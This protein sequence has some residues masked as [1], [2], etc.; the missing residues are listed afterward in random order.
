[1]KKE[2]RGQS[3]SYSTRKKLFS[4][5][6]T[7]LIAALLLTGATFA[8]LT[9]SIA[10]EATGIATQI[11][12]NGS[13]EIA[14]LNAETRADL[15]KIR[16]AGVGASLSNGVNVNDVWGNLIDL[17]SKDYGLSEITLM[18]AR[19]NIKSNEGQYYVGENYL[20]APTYGYDGRVVSV[21]G[22]TYGATFNGTDFVGN[23]A[24]P[25]YG[26][27]GLGASNSMSTQASAIATAKTNIVTYTNSAKN[28]AIAALDKNG[29]DLFGIV[30]A[31][32]AN[33]NATFDNDDKAV[34]TA[35][36]TDLKSAY[37]YI[38]SALRQG[39][40]IYAASEIEDE[41][42]FDQVKTAI[43]D[44]TKDI[45][46][47]LDEQGEELNSVIPEGLL[48][49]VDSA[50]EI[51]NSLNAATSACA[52]LTGGSYTWDQIRGIMDYL[53]DMSQVYIGDKLFENMTY[54]DFTALLGSTFTMSLAPSSGVFVS[55]AD[56]TGNYSSWISAMGSKVEIATLSGVNPAYLAGLSDSVKD[57]EAAAGNASE[58]TLKD[59]Y[60][61]ALD[62]A[63]RCNAPLSD[64]LLQTG[65][66]SRVDS[67]DTGVSTMGAGSYMEFSIND[68]SYTPDQMLALMDAVRVAFVDDIGTVMGIAK[69]NTSNRVIDGETI[70]ASLYLY[71][72]TL[73][74]DEFS[75]GSILVMGERRV[76]D[77]AITALTQ[78]TAKAV[79]TIVW[80][81]G[82][83]V[84][85]TMVSAEK[86]ATLT[87]VLNLQFASSA[88]LIPAGNEDLKNLTPKKSDLFELIESAK[89]IYEAGQGMY[90]SASWENFSA[91][92][93]KA[94]AVYND[95]IANDMAVLA[96]A[97]NLVETRDALAEVSF[98][99]LEEKIAEIRELMGETGDLACLVMKDANNL[100]YT[101]KN[102]YTDE[103]FN[104]KIGVINRVNYEKNLKDIGNGIQA[105]I[106]TDESWSILADA[107]YDAEAV[108]NHQDY[109][110]D[111]IISNAI[112]ALDKAY[113]ALARKTYFEAY[114]YEGELYYLA[115]TDAVDTYGKWYDKNH[116]L[117][118]SD[119]TILK[120]DANA[121]LAKIAR[122]AINKYFSVD[123]DA[124]LPTIT[125]LASKYPSLRNEEIIGI[126]WQ[127]TGIFIALASE[128]NI[129]YLYALVEDKLA[130][131]CTEGCV[132]I[133]NA[134]SILYLDRITTD[135]IVPAIVALE[136][137]THGEVE[138]PY[139]PSE[140]DD[141]RVVLR[142]AANTAKNVA[143]YDDL[144]M[145]GYTDDQK[146]VMNNLRDAVSTIEALLDL[147]SLDDTMAATALSAINSQFTAYN[148][149]FEG[150][151]IKQVTIYNSA[152]RYIAVGSE[153]FDVVNG[154]DYGML[155]HKYYSYGA[156]ITG[157][158]GTIK[159]VLLTRSGI[160][161][162]LEET[163]TI[164]AP[165]E[166][167][168]IS[169]DTSVDVG[170]TGHLSVD[171]EQAFFDASQSIYFNEGETVKECFWS[172]SNT[173]IATV[174][175]SGNTAVVTAKAAGTVTISV[176]VT[177]EQGNTY[178]ANYEITIVGAEPEA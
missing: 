57:I 129:D 170:N 6:S 29:N 104:N 157:E 8:W 37:A 90:T 55:I 133:S 166:G 121:E 178:S 177:T 103:Q 148:T 73:E 95:V 30:V 126:H 32:S 31:Y 79:I 59:L 67:D 56:F 22:N 50:A 173:S 11:G 9:I 138:Q 116:N 163:V 112:D 99:L 113:N 75:D 124:M 80:L 28:A 36:I 137:H 52:N 91:A 51:K 3:K 97:R 123:S 155:Y 53:I 39:L 87:G 77:N 17:S 102:S 85:N 98:T 167:V 20:L 119:L 107:L 5:A 26:V 83:L 54:D 175:G 69:L 7:L 61:Y 92:Y 94:E 34:M 161:F 4:A 48:A 147:E 33:S 88:N 153:I 23:L 115:R 128:T 136:N 164:Y 114:E 84:D 140:S 156:D 1:M 108:F 105:A 71:E 41:D 143:G 86:Q 18:P 106:Y 64:L 131:G 46:V 159:A 96:A 16:N 13:L 42:L 120:L 125:I 66:V 145:E 19:L 134:K 12:A 150:D 2:N 142:I 47:I 27:R 65:A 130:D 62:L 45:G 40:V 81:D 44:T 165:A 132:E 72:F 127:E 174:S 162:T 144:V 109:T 58:I 21:S 169:G 158:Q 146:S 135:Q 101:V 15:T 60:G 89:E 172:S 68:T 168:S 160:I 111:N 43:L 82:D 25:G 74:D 49:W 154:S 14:L 78:N 63:F 122:L 151:D 70:K 117:V 110:N 171:L 149:A 139:V 10:P 100:V 93:N 118:T 35:M 38:D 76:D 24:N 141:Y 152:P 176:T